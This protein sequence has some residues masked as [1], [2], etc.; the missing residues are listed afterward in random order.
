MHLRP[1][2]PEPHALLLSYTPK[3]NQSRE[4]RVAFHRLSP[5]HRVSGD[6]GDTSIPPRAPAR[7]AA[8]RAAS[9]TRSGERGHRTPNTVIPCTR[10][11]GALLVHS[12]SLHRARSPARTSAEGGRVGLPSH[13]TVIT[14][15][16]RPAPSPHRLAPPGMQRPFTPARAAGVDGA[17]SVDLR[18]ARPTAAR[19][20]RDR[21]AGRSRRHELG[22][23]Q[24]R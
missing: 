6:T 8:P 3:R 2:G 17:S 14:R 9:S 19:P 12:D 23:A 4:R 1:H 13:L 21:P 16:S 5:T 15:F 22:L 7:L 20:R 18:T 24:A 10:L 11:A